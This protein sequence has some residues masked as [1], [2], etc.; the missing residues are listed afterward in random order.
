MKTIKRLINSMY[1]RFL[2]IFISA[3]IMALIIAF[4]FTSL[5]QF[6]TVKSMLDS[7][8]E[9]K[10]DQLKALVSEE[11]IPI[12]NAIGYLSGPDGSEVLYKIVNQADLR[13]T[14][15]E[16]HKVERGEVVSKIAMLKAN[17]VNTVFKI[18]NYYIVL[19]PNVE[20]NPIT[21]LFAIQKI[22][23]LVPLGLGTIFIF[24]AT[25]F[26]LKPIKLISEASQKVAQGTFDIELPVRGH[27][28]FS[29]MIRNFNLMIKALS[30][31]EF[32]HKDFVSNVSHEFK[33]PL[34]S[35]KGYAKLLKKTDLSEEKRQ[36]CYDI[37]IAESDRLSKLSSNL[38]KLAERLFI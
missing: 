36:E 9:N 3:F 23:V 19:S 14:A 11:N 7:T 4:L 13:L 32:L 17:K 22:F 8:F 20:N 12:E 35:L 24:M 31:N 29:E 28:E 38:L 25:L 10:A 33:T 2:T 18:E 26:S 1:F 16:Q 37:I 5:T 6:D 21:I 27:G 30:T 15:D 34:T